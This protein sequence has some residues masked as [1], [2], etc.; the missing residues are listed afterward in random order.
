MITALCFIKASPESVNSA[1]EAIARIPGVRAAYSVTGQI[2]LVALIEVTGHD[3][4]ARVVTDGIGA[5][6]GV[7]STETHIAFRT[8]SRDDLEAG[9]SIGAED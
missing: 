3:D 8:Y 4:V 2:D 6:S 5:V 1:G 7:L 9:F